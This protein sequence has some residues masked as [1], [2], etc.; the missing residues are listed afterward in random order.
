MT[1]P[2]KIL[3]FLDVTGRW[4][5]SLLWV[6]LGAVAVHLGPAQWA[7]RARRPLWSSEFELPRGGRVDGR[8]VVGS[9]LFGLGWGAVGYCPGPAIVDLVAPSASLLAFVGAMM[10]GIATYRAFHRR[11]VP[12]RALV[13][14]DARTT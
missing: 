6:M 8:L 7:M 12:A 10:A 3:G 9:A 13:E 1:N 14:R 11:M 2:D 4:D 5:P